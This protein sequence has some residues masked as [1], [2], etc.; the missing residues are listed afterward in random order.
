[1]TWLDKYRV[2]RRIAFLWSLSLVTWVTYQVFTD[3]PQISAGTATA[4]GTAVGVLSTVIGFYKW[5]RFKQEREH[6]QHNRR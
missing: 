5:S 4:Y 2:L 6:D 3:P 1:M